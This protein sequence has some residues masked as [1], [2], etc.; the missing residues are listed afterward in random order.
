MATSPDGCF[1][2]ANYWPPGNY[3]GRFQQNVLPAGDAAN[4]LAQQ[5]NNSCGVSR[6][7][8]VD[9]ERERTDRENE[10]RQ[11]AAKSE[12]QRKESNVAPAGSSVQVFGLTSTA[13]RAMNGRTGVVQQEQ[14]RVGDGRVSVL[15]DGD[16]TLK[17]IKVEN[18]RRPPP[19]VQAEAERGRKTRDAEARRRPKATAEQPPASETSQVTGPTRF[20]AEAL[21]AHNNYR[22]LHGAP[23]LTWD[24]ELTQ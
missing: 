17:S 20:I 18:L 13:G 1:L 7:G 14:A 6:D 16:D 22:T 19:A 11:Q 12:L 23:P 3:Q 15:L 24:S 2:V 10:A 8:M 9:A 5:T 4:A 21:E